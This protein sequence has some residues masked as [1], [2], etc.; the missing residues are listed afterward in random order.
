MKSDEQ[1]D[2]FDRCE[3]RYAFSQKYESKLISPLGVLY[4]AVEAAL[5]ADD[6]EETA[7]NATMESAASHELILSD[8]NSF[9]TIRH[10]GYL[11]GIIAVALRQRLGALKRVESTAD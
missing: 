11:A 6:P 3:R 2:T 8:L 5:V 10:C 4:A 9:M 7:K 1:F